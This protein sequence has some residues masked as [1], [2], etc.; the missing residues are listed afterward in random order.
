MLNAAVMGDSSRS[1]V[2]TWTYDHKAMIYSEGLLDWESSFHLNA[3]AP[4]SWNQG[5]M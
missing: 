4:S 1:F 5:Q 2:A 3:M